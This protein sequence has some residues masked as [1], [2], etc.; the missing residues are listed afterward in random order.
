M[1]RPPAHLAPTFLLEPAR[2]AF[3]R[4]VQR[5]RSAQEALV[6]VSCEP[7]LR[8]A[9]EFALAL[10]LA[11]ERALDVIGPDDARWTSFLRGDRGFDP[12]RDRVWLVR[13]LDLDSR[14]RRLNLARDA[15]VHDATRAWLWAP[16]RRL[17]DIAERA[18]DLWRFRSEALELEADPSVVVGLPRAWP[19]LALDPTGLG[20]STEG[21]RT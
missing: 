4:V 12:N 18:P 7:R 20:P 1:S 10:G 13:G 8:P 19:E 11:P 9:I 6:F 5:L 2:S 3:T 14:L 16:Y 15:W 21:E 17:G